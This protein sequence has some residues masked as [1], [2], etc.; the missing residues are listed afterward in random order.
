MQLRVSAVELDS[1]IGSPCRE[2]AGR[3]HITGVL[4]FLKEGSIAEGLGVPGQAS[5]CREGSLD[6]SPEVSAGW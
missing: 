6:M 5:G 4:T 1:G 3:H 2:A